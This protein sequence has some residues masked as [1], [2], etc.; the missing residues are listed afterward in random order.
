MEAG[1]SSCRLF[2][3][4]FD[5]RLVTR[6]NLRRIEY[7]A[8]TIPTPRGPVIEDVEEEVRFRGEERHSFDLRSGNARECAL[9]A[10]ARAKFR[11][12]AQ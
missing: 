3:V 9:T 5:G 6:L 4:T 10:A 1:G 7:I 2:R 8:P 12:H 11:V